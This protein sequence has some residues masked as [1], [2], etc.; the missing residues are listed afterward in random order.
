STSTRMYG[1]ENSAVVRL[2]KAVSVTRNTLNGSMKNCS[3][4]AVRLPSRITC[5]DSA[6]AA[7]SVTALKATLISGA[8]RRA[9]VNASTSA[10]SSGEASSTRKSTSPPPGEDDVAAAACDSFILLQRLE[11][12]EVQAVELLADL[13]EEH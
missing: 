1:R 8:R 10:P 4:P 6:S 9:P 5:A 13:E 7:P 2:T 11:V 12:V 3:W